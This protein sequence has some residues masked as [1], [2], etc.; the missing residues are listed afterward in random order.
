MGKKALASLMKRPEFQKKLSNLRASS[1][2]PSNIDIRKTP[3]TK[4]Y[5][6]LIKK[7]ADIA[8]GRAIATPFKNSA[9]LDLSEV[10][11]ERGDTVIKKGNKNLLVTGLAG[12][13]KPPKIKITES[14]EVIRTY[15]MTTA[16][17]KKI[18]SVQ[19]ELPVKFSD[20]EDYL[21]RI[22]T[23]E[24]FK[25]NP[26]EMIYFKFHGHYSRQ[27]FSSID[28]AVKYFMNYEVFKSGDTVD[29]KQ[30]YELIRSIGFEKITED[31]DTYNRNR[32]AIDTMQ[33]NP[34]R[35]KKKSKSSPRSITR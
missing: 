28:D 26:G 12:T 25:L 5:T 7:Y 2:V 8:E 24:K 9:E 32:I 20:V 3:Q 30:Q 33:F 6:S 14:G 1:L 16:S 27:G 17:G 19:R 15:T 13:K 31:I 10:F 18:K 35:K 4:H 11:T 29:K 34:K 23:D 22:E 21:N